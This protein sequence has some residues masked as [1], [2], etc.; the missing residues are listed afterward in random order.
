MRT[1]PQE[2]PNTTFVGSIG[3]V[4]T[5]ANKTEF[6]KVAPT[7]SEKMEMEQGKNLRT[8]RKKIT[9]V[10]GSPCVRA[11]LKEFDMAID[12]AMT[13]VRASTS[14][15]KQLVAAQTTRKIED[16]SVKTVLA[17]R[18]FDA[19]DGPNHRGDQRA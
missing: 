18:S 3:K 9:G 1:E 7:E 13:E 6:F 10:K 2:L 5:E 15:P 12:T 17:I 19:I 8:Q 14:L 16:R 11:R 4:P